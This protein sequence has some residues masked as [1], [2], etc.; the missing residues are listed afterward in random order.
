MRITKRTNLAMRVLM[1]CAVNTDRN[2]TKAQISRVSNSSENHLGHVV[3]R[4]GQLGFLTTIRGRRGGIRLARPA[5]EIS[6]GAVF[7]KMEAEVPLIECMVASENTCPL[8][9]VCR[10]TSSI[11][12]AEEAFYS[13]LDTVMLDGLVDCNEGLSKILD[14]E[15]A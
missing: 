15:P 4:L 8:A 7:R 13:H 3:N 5:S 2:V 12:S 6:I 9:P 1:Y 14:A 11:L 10:L